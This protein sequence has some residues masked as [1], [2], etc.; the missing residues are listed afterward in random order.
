MADYGPDVA[1]VRASSYG[2]IVAYS[3]EARPVNAIDG[4][5]RT[6]WSTGGYSEVVGERL[7]VDLT[8]PVTTDHVDLSQLTGNRFITKVTIVLDGEDAVT[9]DLTDPSFSDDGQRIDL[10]GDRTFSSLEVRIDDANVSGLQ[11]FLGWSNVGIRELTIPGVEAA[12]WIELPTAGLD[13]WTGTSTPLSYL[14]SRWR[15]NPVE[16]YR[17]DPELDLRRIFTVPEARS[18]GMTGQARI[19]GRTDGALVDELLG[20]PGLTEGYPVVEGDD[21]LTGALQDRPSSLLDGDPATA[22]TLG[23][24]NQVGRGVTVVA[25]QP[26]T[27]D[28]LDLSVVADGSHS[29]PT[30]LVLRLDDGTTRT[31]EVP[32]VADS[33]EPGAVTTVRVP[34][35]PFTTST[36]RVEIGS[37][38]EVL[39]REYFSGGDHAMP[40]AIAELGL[41]VTVGPLPTD[42]PTTCRAGLVQVDGADVPVSLQGTV[43]DAVARQPLDVE[44][45]A[46]DA[47]ALDAGEH[48]LQTTAGLDSGVDVDQLELT[49]DPGA[50]ARTTGATAVVTDDGDGD[51]T[52]SPS[53]R[54]RGRRRSPSTPPATCATRSTSP[55]PPSRSGWC[56]ASRSPPGGR[57][58]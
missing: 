1:D 27:V 29:V 7:R 13:E 19:G 21:Y 15:A 3:P 41:P 56:W 50:A 54:R 37:V 35:E 32:P 55:T 34:V 11:S 53:P 6:A 26:M 10:G 22:W 14:F 51:P 48:R 42:V 20:R 5:P 31:V 47:L 43:A 57:R 49:S 8:H 38:R 36:L 58:R 16:G 24:G 25:P 18:F 40:V 30:S 45:C 44:P 33:T 23:F 28:H 9:V 52:T 17:Q 12:E 39:T 2:N 4:D 46:T